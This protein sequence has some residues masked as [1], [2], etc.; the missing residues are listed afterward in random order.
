MRTLFL[1]AT[2]ICCCYLHCFAQSLRDVTTASE[3]RD[4]TDIS[5][6]SL[7]CIQ[8]KY[9]KLTSSLQQQS[10]KMLQR[11]QQKE[12]KLRGKIQKKDSTLAKELFQN[13]ENKY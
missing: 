11:M 5:A 9:T 2:A 12:E 10:A 7:S 1:L 13:S 4:I 8:S 3:S 6:K